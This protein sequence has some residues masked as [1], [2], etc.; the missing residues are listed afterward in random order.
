MVPRGKALSSIPRIMQ[1]AYYFIIYLIYS[2]NEFDYLF[3][4][5][6]SKKIKTYL[7]HTKFACCKP[8]IVYKKNCTF[9]LK[10]NENVMFKI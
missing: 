6:L 10:A 1:E 7:Q 8:I 2:Y 3:S 5:S 9:T 4:E